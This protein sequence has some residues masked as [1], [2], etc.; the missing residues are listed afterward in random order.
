MVVMAAMA[1]KVSMPTPIFSAD[2]VARLAGVVTEETEETR[3]AADK[4]DA[5]ARGGV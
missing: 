5:V 1:H 3:D 2:A 4:A